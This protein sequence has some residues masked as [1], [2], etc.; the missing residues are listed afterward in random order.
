MK[1]QNGFRFASARPNLQNVY[2][3][4]N[5]AFEKTP[6]GLRSSLGGLYWGGTT[7]ANRTRR[8][9]SHRQNKC[10]QDQAPKLEKVT[11]LGRPGERQGM[12]TRLIVLPAAVCSWTEPEELKCRRLRGFLRSRLPLQARS[13]YPW[14][15]S[16]LEANYCSHLDKVKK[17]ERKNKWNPLT[18][19]RRLLNWNWEG[20]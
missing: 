8:G 1:E 7:G 15:Q 9:W 17:N 16:S 18:W 3:P 10:P 4:W 13:L 20:S 11:L 6:L 19:S 2:F 14:R 5:K 12:G